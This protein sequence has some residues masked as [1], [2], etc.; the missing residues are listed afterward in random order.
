MNYEKLEQA[1]EKYT[2]LDDYCNEYAEP[3]YTKDLEDSPIYFA[4]WNPIGEK[5]PKLMDFIEK[6]VNI[7]WSDEW[8]TCRECGKA[9]RTQGNCWGWTAYYHVFN[10]CELICGD[11]I[12]ENHQDE[13][14][15]SLYGNYKNFNRFFCLTELGFENLNGVF[16][17]GWYHVNDD[18]E[19]IMKAFRL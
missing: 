5:S 17:N 13:Y 7:E 19:E 3:G 4:N 9:V 8:A 16:E 14:L 15:E 2:Y 12:Q 6:H 18:P 10:E 11:C 1:I